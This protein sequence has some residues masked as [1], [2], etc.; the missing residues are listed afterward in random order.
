MVQYIPF[1][2]GGGLVLF[3]IAG[4]V[5]SFWPSRSREREPA[6]AGDWDNSKLTDYGGVGG[7]GGGH[8]PP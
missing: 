8:H 7:D 4:F 6:G 2:A 3:L 1:I 5:R